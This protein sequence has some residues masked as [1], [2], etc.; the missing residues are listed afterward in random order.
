MTSSKRG[1]VVDSNV[2]P[3]ERTKIDLKELKVNLKNMKLMHFYRR[4]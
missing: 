2:I 1:L 4:K 3:Q